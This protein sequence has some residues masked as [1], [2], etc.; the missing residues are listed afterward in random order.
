MTQCLQCYRVQFSQAA[1]QVQALLQGETRDQPLVEL[2][3]I[4]GL[5]CSAPLIRVRCHALRVEPS[6]SADGSCVW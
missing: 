1:G 6:L 2:W 3:T 5:A 4:K